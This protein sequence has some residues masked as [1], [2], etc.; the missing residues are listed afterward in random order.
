MFC[1]RKNCTFV[2]LLFAC[3][4]FASTNLVAQEWPQWRGADRQNHSS[5]T[6]LFESWGVDG[7]KLEWTATGLGRGYATV[8]VADGKIYT[9]GDTDTAQQ[10]TA[11]SLDGKKLWA[12]PITQR[13]PKHPYQGSRTTPTFHDGKLYVVGSDG[14]ICCL[15]ADDGKKVWTRNFDE[16]GG[17]M[18]SV[19]GFSESPLVD[20]GKVICSPGGT[21]GTVVALDPET[22]KDIWACTLPDYGDEMGLNGKSLMDGAGYSSVVVSNGGGVKQYVQ[23]VGRGLIGIR[24]SDG[25]LLWRY[26][27]VAN[28]TANI[29]TAVIDGDY[30]FTSTAYNTGA[31]LLKLSAAK[32]GVEV[33]EI[34]WLNSKTFQNKLGG[35]TLVDGHIYCGHGNGSGLPICIEMMTGKVKWGPIRAKGKGESSLIVAD[36]HIVWRR[37]NGEVIL[38]KVNSEEMEVVNSFMPKIQED[39]SWAQPVIA[40]GV[41]YLREQDNLMAYRLK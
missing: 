11:H 35:M 6:G 41:M 5:E 36:G 33:E 22:G 28:G 14:S 40:D 37:Q 27:K 29:P 9:S 3:C 1:D 20:D 30:V 31:A 38:T 16:W 34:Y 24:A 7:P 39:N 15:N 21:S 4:V 19:W 10:V 13:P 32:D 8:S 12:T 18:M 26:K 2:I 25:K 23:L 17:K